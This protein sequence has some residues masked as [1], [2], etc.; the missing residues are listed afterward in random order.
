MTEYSILGE[1]SLYVSWATKGQTLSSG[2]SL[3]TYHLQEFICK[4]KYYA[5]I[6]SWKCQTWA[7]LWLSSDRNVTSTPF[8][9]LLQNH[10]PGEQSWPAMTSSIIINTNP[11][12]NELSLLIQPIGVKL[13]LIC[14]GFCLHN[15]KMLPNMEI[16]HHLWRLMKAAQDKCIW[17]EG[18]IQNV[19]HYKRFI[20]R[21]KPQLC[22]FIGNLTDAHKTLAQ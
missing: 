18:I 4:K 8:I 21:I 16:T 3:C 14:P 5:N 17:R 11:C 12:E 19:D 2:L 22:S 15:M 7:K 10:L 13:L 6:V 9:T 20:I 1:L